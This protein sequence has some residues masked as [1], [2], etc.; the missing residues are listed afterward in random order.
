VQ[1]DSCRGFSD[2]YGPTRTPQKLKGLYA[3]ILGVSGKLMMWFRHHQPAKSATTYPHHTPKKVPFGS[4]PRIWLLIHGLNSVPF[5]LPLEPTLFP[6]LRIYFADF[7]YSHSSVYHRLYTLGTC[8]GYGYELVGTCA[9]WL[10]S[11]FFWWLRTYTNP[12]KIERPLR[13]Y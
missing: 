2:G 12:P 10:L 8:C 11:R 1:F 3:D 9:I 4:S 5:T 13:W 6:K 7:P